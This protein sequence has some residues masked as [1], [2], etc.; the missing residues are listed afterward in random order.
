[1]IAARGQKGALACPRCTKRVMADVTARVAAAHPNSAGVSKSTMDRYRRT[2]PYFSAFCSERGL[3]GVDA[4]QFVTGAGSTAAPATTVMLDFLEWMSAGASVAV[5]VK[6][7]SRH[8]SHEIYDT[9]KKWLRFCVNNQL[10]AVKGV[11]VGN[12]WC[13]SLPGIKAAT[14]HVSA[15][16][17]GRQFAACTE[18][19][20]RSDVL[21]SFDQ[22]KLMQ[23][24]ALAGRIHKDALQCLTAAFSFRGMMAMANRGENF[25]D[26]RLSFV[27]TRE[28][29][30]VIGGEQLIG[31]K[32]KNIR[33]KQQK[34]G[35]Y[36]PT[37]TA[38]FPHRN[39]LLCP[40][41]SLGLLL[42]YRFCV[43]KESFPNIA[44]PASWCHLFLIRA[45]RAR[46]R[47]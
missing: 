1:M 15:A 29:S 25:R 3:C 30:Q 43:L 16:H 34:S 37:V 4:R 39:P 10:T 46:L 2:E 33:G 8:V 45:T 6:G 19:D 35:D 22:M 14:S 42:L 21:L 7:K 9:A 24:A 44:A 17:H 31:L 32:M 20:Q 26:A 40:I 23:H 28:Y 13:S 27:S 11:T 41:V 38:C 5:V 36:V 12:G 18:A 47:A